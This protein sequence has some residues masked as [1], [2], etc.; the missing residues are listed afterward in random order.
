MDKD[1]NKSRSDLLKAG[2]K[3]LQQ[4]REKKD[5]KGGSSSSPGKSSKKSN[6]SDQRQSDTD[7]ASSATMST[8]SSLPEVEEVSNVDSDLRVVD[9]DSMENSLAPET[10][11]ASVDPSSVA[12]TPEEGIVDASLAHDAE[13]PPLQSGVSD[14]DSTVPKNK[15]STQIVDDEESRAM[16]SATLGAPVLEGETKHADN[17]GITNLRA[18]SASVDTAGEVA[19]M[20]TVN[21]KEREEV[22]PSQKVIP[23]TSLIQSS[24]DQVT[25]VGAMQEADDLG[26]KKFDRSGEPELEGDGKLVLSDLGGSAAILREADATPATS[27]QVENQLKDA[28]A[29]FPDEEKSG[30]PFDTYGNDQKEGSQAN[31]ENKTVTEIHNQQ[32]MPEDSLMTRD[33]A[34]E[35]SLETETESSKGPVSNAELGNSGLILPEYCHPDLFERLKEELYLTNFGKDIFHLQLKEMS[36]MEMEFDHQQLQLVDEISLLRAS[37]NED[38]EKKECLAEELAHCRSELQAAA[39]KT[40]DLENQVHSVTVEAHEFSS[41]AHELQISLERSQGDLSNLSV[42]L[43]DCKGLVATLQVE[44]EKLNGTLASMTEDGKK[45]VE[46]KESCLHEN[47]KL[48]L[49]LADCKSIIAS[50]QIENSNLSGTLTSVTE[51]RKKLEEEKESHAC[52]YARISGELTDCKGLVSALQVENAN[53]NHSL[54]L[55]TEEREKIEEDKEY[56]IRE[57]E[58]LLNELLVLQKKFPSVNTRDGRISSLV[59]ETPSSDNPQALVVL[60][61]HLEEAEKILQNLEKAIEGMHSEAM[62]FSRSSGKMSAPGVSKLIQAFESKVQHDELEAED[63]SLPEDQSPADPFKL[64]K[65]Q[66][67]KLRTVL[68]QLPL[69]AGDSFNVAATELKIE[70][71]ALKKNCDNLEATNIELGVLYEAV[72]QNACD[73]EAKNKEFVVQIEAL[74]REDISLKAE[75]VELGEKVSEY[76]SR[77]N[78]LMSQLHDLQQSSDE[79]TSVMEYQLESLQKEATERALILEQEWESTIAQTIKMMGRLD[80]CIARVSGSAISTRTDNGLDV[81]SHIG[82][83]VN[84]TIKV[85]EGLQ[86]KKE[87]ALEDLETV[88]GSYKEVN[89]KLNDL[90]RKNESASVTLHQIYGDLRKLLIDSCGSVD[91]LDI[92]IQAGELVDPLDYANYKTFV[93][94][95]E[96]LLGERLQLQ[97]LNNKLNSELMSRTSDIEELNRRGLTLKVIQKLAEDVE[98]VVNL[99]YSETDSGITPASHLESLVSLLV[100]KYNEASEQASTSRNLF[101]NTIR[102]LIEEVD[103]VVNLE[104][105]DTDLDLTPALHLELLVSSLVQKY[106]E[107]SER[108][109]S[110]REDFSNA[111]QKLV[112]D[113]EGV[114]ILENTEADLDITPALRLELL[115]SS[116]VQKYKEVSVW[117]SSSTEEFSNTIQK[118]IGDIEGVVNLRISESNS[119]ITPAL[120][121]ELL[122]SSLVQKYKETSEQVSSSTEEFSNTVQ[123]LIVDIDGVLKMEDTV[124]NSDVTPAL[125]LESLVS[126]LVQKYKEASEQGNSSTEEFSTTIQKLIGDIEG[127]VNLGNTENNS[128]ITPALHLESLVSS[129]VQ[130]Y[131]GVG[132]RVCS[133]NEEFGSKAMEMTELQEKIQQLNAF[134]LKHENEILALKESL[135]QAEEALTVAR[136]ELQE[137]ASEL[138]QSDQRVSSVREKLGIAVGKGKALVVQRD[139]LK[140]SLAETSKD[141]ERCSQELQLKDA[142]LHELETQLKTY[143]EAGERVESLESE[144]SYIRNSATALRESFLLKDSVLQRIEEILEDLDLPEQFHSRGIIEKVDWLARS[145]AGNSL[146]VTEWD[147]KSSV[148]GSYS[149]AWKEDAPPSSSSG[150]DLRRNYEEL[151]NKFYGLAEQTEMLEQSLMGRNRMVQR[152]DELLDRINMPSHLRSVELEGRIEWLGTAL[153]EADHDRS[154]LLQKIDRLENY[155]GLVTADLEES[156]KRIS[157]LEADLQAV[158]HESE[159]LSERLE[160]LTSEEEGILAKAFRFE[161]ENGKL[162]S[163]VTD[164]QEKLAEKVGNEER[165][166]SIEVE[167]LKLEGLVSDALQD[168]DAKGLVSGDCGT[169]CLEALLRKLIEHYSALSMAKPVHGNAVDV[170]QTTEADANLD[171]SG[172]RHIITTEKPDVAVLRKDLEE[173]MSNLMHV[174]EERDVYVEKQQSL[175]FEVDALDRKREELQEQ[176]IQEEQ[177]SASLR[178]KLN[179]AVRKGKSLVQQRDS[180]KQTLEELNNEVDRL[181]SEISHRE[182]TLADNEQKIRGLSAYPEMVEALESER[183]F[184]RNRLTE[185]EHVL[186]EREHIL[187][188]T[189]NALGDVDVGGEVTIDDPVEKLKQFG[190]LLHDLHASLASSEQESKKS[191]RV[192]ELLLAELNEVQERNDYLQEELAKAGDELAETSRER[193]VAEAAKFE[194]LSRFEKLSTIY[195]EGKQKQYY[196]LMVLK[197][198]VKELKKGF[199]DV[200]S[201]LADVFSKD[202]E[203]LHNLEANMESCLKQRDTTDLPILSAYSGITSS[204]SQNKQNLLSMDSWSGLDVRDHLDDSAIVDVCSFVEASLQELKTDVVALKDKLHKHPI[205]LQERASNLSKV[206]EI[207]RGEMNLQKKSL[208]ALKRDFTHLESVEK[209]KDMEIVVLHRNIALL[210][211]ACNNSIM[212]I[213]NKKAELVGNNSVFGEQGMSLNPVTSVDGDLPSGGQAL[214]NS[215]EYIKA[216]VDRLS[217]TLKDFAVTKSENV[218]GSLKEMKATIADLQRELQEKD[219]RRDRIFSDLVAQIKGAEAAAQSYLQ[220]LQSEKSRVHDMEQQLKLMEEERILLEQRLKELRDD[221]AT[222]TKLQDRVKSLS[223]VLPAKD[224]EIEALMQALDEEEIQMDELKNR[225]KELEKV[226]QQK[227]L[228]LQNL[229]ASRGKIAKRLSVTV[230]K[231]DELHHLSE[232]LLA[233]VEKLQSQIQDRDAEISFLRQEVTRCT[234]EVL[235]ASRTTNN[236]DSDEIQEILSWV[237]TIISQTGVH[238]LHL[239][240]KESSQVQCRELLQKKISAII[241]EFVDQ[242]V[243]AQSRDAMLQVE[244]SKVQELTHREEVLRKSLREKESQINMLEDVEDSGRGNSLTSEILEVEPLVNKWTVPGPSTTSQVRSLRKVNNDQVAIAIN[245]ERDSSRLEDE[246]DDKVHGFKSLTTS[247]IVPRFTRPVTDMIDGLWVSCDR[248]LMRQP[249]LR[250]SIIVYWA[251]LHTLLASL[252]F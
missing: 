17:S 217:L 176:L 209:E 141:L 164:L 97:S 167:L 140:Q 16:P 231:F 133:S 118:L 106:K 109:S 39:S 155:C 218:E 87:A 142:R 195:S 149:D 191:R 42:E 4:F 224:Q 206:M 66:T 232:S 76:R 56:F 61:A 207:L 228:D 244:R 171:E 35:G 27:Q 230:N 229:E 132:D 252:V 78:E 227:N 25:D 24:G 64:I 178:E 122:V 237:D 159:H 52:G 75:Y 31:A 19:E 89:E 65:E 82:A 127:V 112:G 187:N 26:L 181:K 226:L 213:V 22:S 110:S 250:L 139:N 147:Q 243:A 184:L 18:S 148:G 162:Q 146:P 198:S 182:N 59:L 23:D 69:D 238:D 211:E 136:S 153:T 245:T 128:D 200:N 111:I 3:K 180:L 235:A 156:Q 46:E 120:R 123:K 177:K 62:S 168:P 103:C 40:G 151:Q 93:E 193:E 144:L 49:E 157:E 108:V 160:I 240:D 150:D 169:E 1:K 98:G 125:R 248:A 126:S 86:E 37:L 179:V 29:G 183:V 30:I 186:Q 85:I 239:D 121:L 115:V 63:K 36:D 185:T 67:G 204:N 190:K 205:S 70:N 60:K 197:T 114:V 210:Y 188:S 92:N 100:Q 51:E 214:F 124:T 91:E 11:V 5:G 241:S 130:K 8:V 194:A 234:N 161:Y 220:D 79:K 14:A 7:A 9:S 58:R 131:K 77:A 13:L 152:C 208:E 134:N 203:V 137:K 174:K 225:I 192:A 95:L 99:Q 135:G 84:A 138:E 104:N 154:S 33:K 119:D 71:E 222:L 158:I 74:K 251:V 45:L 212:D 48:S 247:R 43:A 88:H 68:Q 223:D 175:I 102:K 34:H 81:N 28:V 170:I 32:Y 236:R 41:R 143:M 221:Q 38:Q 50:L 219:I 105:T 166:Q 172:S 216:I 6:K 189:I 47:E 101:S 246:D 145:A 80:E 233:E 202:L 44:N 107:A 55:I 94:Q 165:I 196:E 90:V 242:R 20:D 54:S 117:V 173:A 21:G 72:K 116:L 57:N 113:I 129:L 163:E 96:N 249:A 199:S 10:D 215:E 53:I 15:E 12:I 2:R 83:S 201:L 73:V